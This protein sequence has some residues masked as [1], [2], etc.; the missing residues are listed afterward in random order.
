MQSRLEKM[1]NR[2]VDPEITS[3]KQLNEVYKRLEQSESVK[4]VIGSMQSIDPEYTRNTFSEGDRVKNQLDEHLTDRCKFRY[5]GS[6]TNDTHIKAR[7]DIDLLVILE[8]YHGLEKPQVPKNPYK[9]NPI[10]DMSG[11]RADVINVLQAQFPAVTVDSSGSKSVTLEGGSLRRKIDVVPANWFNTNK[12]AQNSDEV[13][14]GV[15]VFDANTHER[16]PN[17]PFLHNAII[18][19]EDQKTNGGIRKAARLM[20]SLKYDTESINLS[21]YDIVSIAYQIPTDW[22]DGTPGH[23][24]QVLDSCLRYCEHLVA[25]DEYRNK[26][27]VPDAHRRIFADGHAT[28]ED[29]VELVHALRGLTNDVL[30]ENARSFKKLAD[31]RIEYL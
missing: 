27:K 13:Y 29:L 12:Y 17:T 8:R 21:S 1:S 4:Y 18:D 22:V 3:A 9:G 14:R 23:E 24:L 5:Q 6:V 31:A 16:I 2:R 7:S 15:E 10:E 26:L 28:P 19:A 25:D 11:L 30:L 20:K